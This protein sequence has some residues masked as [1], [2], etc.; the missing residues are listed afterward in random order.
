[1]TSYERCMAALHWERPDRV[2]VV[3]QNS[4]MAIHLAGYDMIEASRDPVKLAISL[5]QSQSRFGYDG[6]LLGPDAAILA[7]AVGCET[8]YRADDPPAIVGCA[9]QN[10]SEVKNLKVP[11]MAKDGRMHVWLDAIRIIRQR[12]GK[13]VFLICRADQ[14]AFSLAALIYGMENLSLAIAEGEQSAEI[15]ALLRYAHECHIAFARAIRDAGADMTTCGDSYGGPALIGP[16]TYETLTFP[17]EKAAA[18]YIQKELGIPYSIHICGNTQGIHHIWPKTGAA[19][20]EVDHLTDIASLRRTTVGKNA[21]LGNLDTG[22]LC[23]GTAGEVETECRKLF[24]LMGKESGFLLSSG[25]SMSTNS[26]PDL[27]A[28]MVDAAKEYGTYS[29]T[30]GGNR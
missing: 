3:P 28:A 23:Y 22:L 18:N 12:I 13:S 17:W 5:L 19:C 30:V 21:L 15:E 1:M 26:S 4:D 25:C 7:E 11:D 29:Q 14:C 24:N 27:L 6:I 10:L 9:I 16:Q 8:V 2:P 20:F